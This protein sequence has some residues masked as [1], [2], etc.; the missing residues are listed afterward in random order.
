MSYVI[1]TPA[2]NE[3]RY[4]E[5]T[6]ISILRQTIKPLLWVIVDAG[7]TDG[8]ADVVNHYARQ[9]DWMHYVYHRKGLAG[10]YYARNVYAIAHGY[11]H[12]CTLLRQTTAPL[13]PRDDPTVHPPDFDYVAILDADIELPAHYYDAILTLLSSD[14]LLG[15]AS[16]HCLEHTGTGYR[17]GLYDSRSAPKNIMVFRK[18]CYED[19]GGFVPLRCAGEDTCACY[20]ARMKGWKT[21]AT[22]NVMAMHNKP[23]GT[24]FSSNV[25]AIRFQQG[26]S[27]YFLGTHP[28]FMVAKAAKRSIK[29]PP[30][31]IG[32]LLRLAGFVYATWRR[33]E[34]QIPAELVRFIRNEQLGR[35]L[36]GNRVSAANRVMSSK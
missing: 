6:I 19:I 8:T 33:E 13:T 18:Q 27:E 22:T 9:H 29:E 35:L 1:I 14:S 3:E 4:I 25:H 34:R 21:W 7:S 26:I 12:I 10:S 5:R 2:Y 36:K 16:G 17:R 20:M 31:L 32:G 15:I 11:A 28:L 23:M 30:Y 24:G